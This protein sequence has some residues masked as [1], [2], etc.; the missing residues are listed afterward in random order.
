MGRKKIKQV[1]LGR[2]QINFFGFKPC[3][4][5]LRI[6]PEAIDNDLFHAAGYRRFPTQ[7]GPQ[8]CKQRL[9]S[10]RFDNVIV[11]TRLKSCHLNFLIALRC[12][13]NDD[14]A[15]LITNR[16]AYGQAIGAWQ[17]HIEQNQSRLTFKN[18]SDRAIA[19]GFV[20]D[21]EVMLAQKFDDHFRQSLVILDEE[22]LMGLNRI[23]PIPPFMMRVTSI[24]AYS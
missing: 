15:I 13:H 19:S 2:R 17:S 9:R 11:R 7:V 16:A 8:S 4:T 5:L 21:T 23:H 10:D 20:F 1:K 22:N 18:M 12:Q 3:R 14:A 24:G 6:D